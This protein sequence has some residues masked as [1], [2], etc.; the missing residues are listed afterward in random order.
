MKKMQTDNKSNPAV[1][2]MSKK[3]SR[4]ASTLSID[5][6]TL[7]LSPPPIQFTPCPPAS[8]AERVKFCH[9]SRLELLVIRVDPANLDFIF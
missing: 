5:T 9:P 8:A 7:S 6:L 2:R 1:H 4:D 3:E